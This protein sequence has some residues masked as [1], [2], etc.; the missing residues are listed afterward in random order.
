MQENETMRTNFEAHTQCLAVKSVTTICSSQCYARTLTELR[1][2]VRPRL[3][4][5]KGPKLPSVRAMRAV[6]YTKM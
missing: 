4:T 3:G 5:T 1:S 6:A 2:P